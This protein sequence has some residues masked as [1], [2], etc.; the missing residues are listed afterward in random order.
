[1]LFLLLK[2]LVRAA[3]K[4]A[5]F[6]RKFAAIFALFS[7][8]KIKAYKSVGKGFYRPKTLNTKVIQ[9]ASISHFSGVIGLIS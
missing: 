9:M 2:K 8:P 1:M 3:F 4:R 6:L 7:L 5:A